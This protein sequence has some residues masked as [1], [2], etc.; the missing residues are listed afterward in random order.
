MK[1]SEL[2]IQ[3]QLSQFDI[4]RVR[5]N[6]STVQKPN[7]PVDKNQNFSDILE[8]KISEDNSV[9]FSSHASKRLVE[10]N[11]QVGEDHLQ[12]LE[13]GMSRV[14]EKGAKSSLFLMDEMAFVVSVKNQTVFT[15]VDGEAARRKFFTNLDSVELF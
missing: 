11:M 2:Q 3:N 13:N 7:Q 5:S 6:D 12:R 4:G 9:R 1:V 15:A 8:K 10:R 14:K